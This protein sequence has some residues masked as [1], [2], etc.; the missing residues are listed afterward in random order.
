MLG[1]A[2]H[3]GVAGSG[4]DKVGVLGM[5]A[6]VGRDE[7]ADRHEP[8]AAGADVLEREANELRADPGAFDRLVDLGVHEDD[9]ARLGSVA[10]EPDELS[11]AQ[12]LV[13]QLLGVVPDHQLAHRSPPSTGAAAASRAKACASVSSSAV[14]SRPKKTRCTSSTCAACALRASSRPLWSEPCVRGATV[15]RAHV[16]LDEAPLLERVDDPRD[17]AERQAGRAGELREPHPALV[18]GGEVAEQLE[19]AHREVEP[20]VQPGFELAGQLP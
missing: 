14:E 6:Q 19:A 4:A 18:R 10:D 12:R 20:G 11:V 5:A 2:A 15:L 9:D 16:A 13:P 17:P 1:V 7:R 8:E 3:S